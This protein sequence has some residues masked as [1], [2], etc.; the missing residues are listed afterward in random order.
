MTSASI[1]TRHSCILLR[2]M[3]SIWIP[4]SCFCSAKTHLCCTLPGGTRAGL[5]SRAPWA[6]AQAQHPE[7]SSTLPAQGDHRRRRTFRPGRMQALVLVEHAPALS[8][9]S[10]PEAKTPD[11]A[12]SLR[13]PG[14]PAGGP[15]DLP[16]GCQK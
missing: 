13:R 8:P 3:M 2:Q 1:T 6:N 11:G 4:R 7:I 10:R 5:S 12:F 15:W 16:A 9:S 14:F